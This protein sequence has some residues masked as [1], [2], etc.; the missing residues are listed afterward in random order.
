M[1]VRANYSYRYNPVPMD[2]IN[3]ANLGLEKGDIVKVLKLHGCPPPNTMGQCHVEKDGKFMG[4]VSTNSLEKKV[5][6][7]SIMK[8]TKKYVV[9]QVT[10]EHDDSTDFEEVM[11]ECDYSFKSK[12]DGGEII[13]T[14]IVGYTA[15]LQL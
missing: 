4:M 14:E 7:K 9:V 3:S 8:T 15:K 6:E 13:E 10:V 12:V 1:R 11:A 5:V 2:L